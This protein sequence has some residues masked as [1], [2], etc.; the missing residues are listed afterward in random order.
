MVE[1]PV[2]CVGIYM[3]EGVI[4]SVP[5]H[6]KIEILKFYLDEERPQNQD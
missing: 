3:P 4:S 5:K 1:K 2:C 6:I